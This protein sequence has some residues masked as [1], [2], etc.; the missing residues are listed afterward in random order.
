[1]FCG[2]IVCCYLHDLFVVKLVFL[3]DRY[4]ACMD[5]TDSD[6]KPVRCK[7]NV[8][9]AHGDKSV[10]RQEFGKIFRSN[11]K[12]RPILEK[13]SYV[14]ETIVST[15]NIVLQHQDSSILR[16]TN[17]CAKDTAIYKII[18]EGQLTVKED[19]QTPEHRPRGGFGFPRWLEV[20]CSAFRL[21]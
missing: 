9:I 5:V 11:E 1:M 21:D 13:L 20:S 10:R 17:K 2:R 18:C 4:E 8:R 16:I 3:F 19:G 15:N 6:H 7:F 12:I 14:P